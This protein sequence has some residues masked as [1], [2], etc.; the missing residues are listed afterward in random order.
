[1]RPTTQRRKI[2]IRFSFAFV[3]TFTC[4]L[5]VFA[6]EQGDVS[7][8]DKGTPPQQAS[9]VS[10]LGSYISTD[11]GVVN[12]GNGALS[13]KLPLGQVG[14]R[15]F[16]VPISLNYSSKLWSAT[17]SDEFVP[18]PPPGHRERLVFA[19]YDDPNNPFDFLG[20][21]MPGWTI[22]G[23]PA[24]KV[25][26]VGIAASNN[27]S[28]GGTNFS[29]L[30]VK[31]TLVLP[32][33]GEIQLRDDQTDG[34]PLPSQLD[35]D[36]CRTMDGYRGRRWHATDGSGVIF[37]GDS[38]N[39]VIRG[40]LSGTVI[41][42]N[43]TRYRFDGSG[44]GPNVRSAYL[45]GLKRSS[46]ITDRNGNKI[47]ITYPSSTKVVFTDQLGRQSWWEFNATVGGTRWALV[48][49]LPGV[50]GQD[51]Y[52]KVRTAPMNQNYRSDVNPT[53][54]VY[55]GVYDPIG[56][57]YEPPGPY[58][59]L[60]P[61][62]NG[63]GAERIDN[64]MVLTELVLPDN[65]SLHF[66]YN[67]FG[68]IAEVVT[69]TGGKLQYDYAY[70]N[71]LPS[72][73][74]LPVEVSAHG[75][76]VGTSR[77]E[78][79]D[80]AVT[81]CRHYP[82]G[83]THDI[84]WTYIYNATTAD[85]VT[86][87]ST[88][89]Q[90]RRAVDNLLLSQQKHYFLG[91]QRY[92]NPAGGD[93]EGTG[94]AL[95]S[96]GLERRSETLTETG[97]VLNATEQD[98]TQRAPVV[99]AAYAQEQPEND[100][101]VSQKRN[102]LD[103]GAFARTD[104][105]YD[106]VN[107]VRANN[108]A[109]TWE[110]DFDQTLKRRA[111]TNYL[112]V[113][114]DNDFIDYSSD[115]IF[116]LSLP[117]QQAIYEGDVEKARMV[118]QY[119]KYVD[120]GDSATLTDYGT[121]V[122]GHDGAYGSGR[123]A[124]GNATAVGRWL[125]TGNSTLFTYSRYDTLGN[126]V[127]TKDARGNVA[128]ISYADN[129]GAGDNPDSGVVGAFGPTFAL[130]TLITSP[131]PN[132]GGQP[133]TAKSQY[134]F[135]TGLLTGFKDRNG[136]ITKTEY[137][138]PFNRPTRVINAKGV[139]NVETQTAMY[140]APQ[141][142]PYGVTLTRNDVLTAKDRDASGDGIL[143]AWTVTDGF[144][145]TVESWARHPQGDVKVTTIYD[146]LGR[147]SQ[148]SNPHRNGETP[149]YTTTTYDMA[150]RVTAVTTPDNAQV[151]TAY[152]GNQVTVTDQALKKRRSESDALGRL[153][154]VTEDPGGL[155]F[156]TYYSYDALGNLRQVTQGSQTR[157]FA[158]DSLSRLTSA[159]NPESGTV[160]YAY[161][162]NGNLM[163][164]TDARGVR[165]T[166]TYDALSRV[167]SKVYAGTTPAGT[168]AANATPPVNYFY[169]EYS[170][171]PSGAPS[172]PGT[173]SK[174]RLVGVTYG[175]GSEGTYYK[176]DAAGRIMSNHQRMGTAN[177]LTAYSYNRAG[178]V[179]R[180]DRG[181]ASLTRRR[182]WMYYD[183]AGR[184]S[185]MDSGA[186]NGFGIEPLP[187][188]RDI[189]YTPFGGLQSETYN[190]GL[191]HSMSY[192]ER[193][194]PAEI[195]LGRPENLDSVFRLGYIYGT[196]NDV[197]GQDAEITPAHNNGNVA[198]IKYFISGT[199][200]YTQ[201]F[202]YDPLNRLRYAVEHNNG[203][204]NDTARAWYQTFDYDRYGNRGVNVGNTSDNVDGANTALQLADFSAAN[205]RITR[206][207]YVY[208]A[209]GNLIAEPGKSYTYDAENRIVSATVAGGVT[210]Q[211]FYDGNGRRVKKVVGG[212]GTRFEYGA[213]GELIA[214]WNDADSNKIVQKD[215]FYKGGE[216]IATTKAGTSGQYE[217]AASDH[218]GSPRAWTDGSGNLIAGGR[219][220][221]LP[222]G[223]ELSAGMGIRTAAL[224]YGADSTRQ[225]FTGKQR[226]AETGL[227]YF[228][229]R[230]FS[231]VQGRFISPDEFTGGPTELFA[232]VA[233]HNST[234]YADIFDPQSLNKYAYCLNN[235]L[236]F[237]DPDGHQSVASDA[238]ALQTINSSQIA[239][240]IGKAI[241]NIYI[242][243]KNASPFVKEYTPYYEPS[244]LHQDYG[245]TIT[246]HLTVVGSFL[247]TGGP[248]NVI[249]AEAKPAAAVAAEVGVARR[250]GG[251]LTEP[252]LPSK[253]VVEQNGVKIVHYT[254][255]GDHAPAHLHVKGQ[256]PE[257]RI[258]QNGKPLKNN[259]ELSATQN[260]VVTENKA[261]IRKAV[262]KIQRYH[263]FHNTD[264]EN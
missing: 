189:S 97:G 52:Y 141:S 260:K 261:A 91:A 177:Y 133:H 85:G 46:S 1:M 29:R 116:L 54:P 171:L 83:S 179:T 201:T 200:Q 70:V 94:Y 109:E 190:N 239:V 247:G 146:E 240:G 252:T 197:N 263:R 15:G 256:G 119:D 113:N 81:T 191:I 115:D 78:E 20:R 118:Y 5:S 89:V 126:V 208:D 98:W 202:Q 242:G 220:D 170:G 205:N 255:S 238:L 117:T 62:S 163:E 228:E 67:E 35:G 63:K 187:L 95:W 129:F 257:V 32:D 219:H 203:T 49:K 100:N 142:N 37:I 43:G 101:R 212:V 233:A 218:L 64:K 8:Y 210:S 80:R 112:R 213:G 137:N 244:N 73:N 226:D 66:R 258:G 128:T 10:P 45:A 174:G 4:G 169:D 224:G 164:K 40:D 90:A 253:T 254:A 153:I 147:V 132:P 249:M 6:Q 127:S 165:T 216:L 31:L 23:A 198:R 182:N 130:P 175:P 222:F 237:V 162:A 42:P 262:D 77:V 96:T 51:V 105:F 231:S 241:A 195:S 214:E 196:A 156:E 2:F 134:D 264:P 16:W 183:A 229:A 176:Y 243:M 76:F 259:P 145:R 211:Y 82:D 125:D 155:N 84:T 168:A 72:G 87:G 61:L 221:Y 65:R 11:I 150:G 106:N 102:Y 71:T 250:A 108:V 151:A 158:Y 167:K 152:S 47:T 53:L 246:E 173:P 86:T 184:L 68:E 55:N 248:A 139:T 217:Y 59:S 154:N 44:G 209:A 34:E 21:V 107:N 232:E 121:S 215:Y 27:P 79:I 25:Q 26:G 188:V 39:G 194:Q 135:S 104:I 225:K 103:T 111:I 114:P 234:F 120:D 230:Y 17:K 159:T 56:W 19:V 160:T 199:L 14:G 13:I 7:Q 138:D 58:T 123:T 22:G 227:D 75:Q 245:M 38:D 236:I 3:L 124:R 251:A 207:D 204:H 33:K 172:W 180:E 144:G 149:V 41:L 18:E 57:G 12:L 28:C 93:S 235:P 181:G 30:L 192:N 69:P 178:A 36:G 131:P 99:W 24:L 157:T 92:L 110:Y 60:F 185:A 136:A 166:M 186:Y 140:Y 143:R 88:E 223:E 193:L 48:V 122:T 161:D 50:N 206:A 148:S 9:G 74:S